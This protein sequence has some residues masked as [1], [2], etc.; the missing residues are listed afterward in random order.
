[1]A[2]ASRGRLKQLAP[3]P[4]EAMRTL[5][6]RT[7]TRYSEG[8]A[9]M[10]P[11]RGSGGRRAA[12]GALMPARGSRGVPS[13]S[14]RGNGTRCTEAAQRRARSDQRTEMSSTSNTSVELGGMT[15]G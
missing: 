3:W 11:Q 7:W 9:E 14:G 8:L 15:G 12:R 6:R 13:A 10:K 2:T 5:P 4:E 1:M